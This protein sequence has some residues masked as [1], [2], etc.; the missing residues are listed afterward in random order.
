MLWSTNF[1]GVA[2]INLADILLYAYE[3]EDEDILSNVPILRSSPINN[4]DDMS[5]AADIEKLFDAKQINK[6]K[7][8]LLSRRELKAPLKANGHLC[9]PGSLT[10]ADFVLCNAENIRGCAS[11]LKIICLSGRNR[12]SFVFGDL[13]R[14]NELCFLYF[15][16]LNTIGCGIFCAI[17]IL[18]FRNCL[19]F[20]IVC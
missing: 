12:D 7:S 9:P 19:K 2:N 20:E 14:Q 5:A 4:N 3:F 8:L 1:K 13:E 10:H 18:K 16:V 6:F 17:I 15:S 11:V